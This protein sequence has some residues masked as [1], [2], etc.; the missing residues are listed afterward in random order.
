MDENLLKMRAKLAKNSRYWPLTLSTT[1]LYNVRQFVEPILI[2]TNKPEL[3]E[4]DILQCQKTIYQLAALEGR[5]ESL[6]LPNMGHRLKGNKR[7]EQYRLLWAE[8]ELNVSSSG[9]SPGH[10]TVLKC[11]RDC[12]SRAPIE[13]QDKDEPIDAHRASVIRATTDSPMSPPHSMAVVDSSV[14]A[15][16]A[17]SSRSSKKVLGGGTKSLFDI[18]ATAERTQSQKRIDFSG[19]LC[20]PQGQE[21]KLYPNLGM[22]EEAVAQGRQ[23]DV[24]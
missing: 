11:I 10:K 23:A 19:R 24:K 15:L 9:T 6:A 2:L 1:V 20:T 14:S 18:L 16:L 5:Q 8:L 13:I 12:R 7:E 3:A 17:G 4:E 21:A 22:K